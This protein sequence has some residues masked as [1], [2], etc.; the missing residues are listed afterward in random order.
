[1][2]SEY[3]QVLQKLVDRA[4]AKAEEQRQQSQQHQAPG[5]SLKR[6]L[7]EPS[8]RP[9]SAGVGVNDPSLQHSAQQQ[10]A[11]GMISQ[12]ECRSKLS[13][14]IHIHTCQACLG[15]AVLK[16]FSINAGLSDPAMWPLLYQ[17]AQQQ[18]Q[19]CLGCRVRR[20]PYNRIDC[21][22]VPLLYIK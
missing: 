8:S 7:P 17:H 11:N 18:Q 21:L 14:L 16:W 13:L 20:L 1:M 22:Q 2:L 3:H 6:P 5:A 9:S 4:C 12:G 15:R 19:R 10:L